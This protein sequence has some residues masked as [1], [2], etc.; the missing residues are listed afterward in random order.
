MGY[1]NGG[2]DS[3]NNWDATTGFGKAF[4][5]EKIGSNWYAIKDE[6]MYQLNALYNNEGDAQEE[7]YLQACEPFDIRVCPMCGRFLLEKKEGEQE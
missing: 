1:E 7:D 6:Y 2:C 4:Y 5:I 3:C